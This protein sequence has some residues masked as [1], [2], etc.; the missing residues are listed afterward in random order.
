MAVAGVVRG[1]E[2]LVVPCAGALA[3]WLT[4]VLGRRLDSTRTGAAAARAACVQSECAVSGRAA[5][6]GRR[7]DGLVAARCGARDR[8]AR[9]RVSTV[10]GGAGGGDGGVDAAESVAAGC[11]DRSV[12]GVRLQPDL[13]RSRRS[14]PA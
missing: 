10:R 13:L 6:D 3:V 2:F 5:D 14:R 4:F 8:M 7:G 1:G 12:R 11:C 9:R